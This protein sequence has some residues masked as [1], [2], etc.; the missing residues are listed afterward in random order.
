[1]KTLILPFGD[2]GVTRKAGEKLA[3]LLPGAVVYN[4]KMPVEG[5]DNYVLGTNVHFGKFNKKFLTQ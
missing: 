2:T 4:D 3:S 5:Y 1:M